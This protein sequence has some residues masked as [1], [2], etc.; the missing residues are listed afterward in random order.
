MAGA[1]EEERS[2]NHDK[3]LSVSDVLLA[4]SSSWLVTSVVNDKVEDD[5]ACLDVEKEDNELSFE[6]YRCCGTV[7]GDTIQPKDGEDN[8]TTV[9][10]NSNALALI[11]VIVIRKRKLG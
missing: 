7:G 9:S 2:L 6:L 3:Y 11:V 1:E 4:F 8:T 5:V 10:S